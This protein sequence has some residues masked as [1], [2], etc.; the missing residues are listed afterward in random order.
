[1]SKQRP[2]FEKVVL[3][4]KRRGDPSKV[5]K[6]TVTLKSGLAVSITPLKDGTLVLSWGDKK[7]RYLNL[8]KGGYL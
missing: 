7:R 2:K 6:V 5:G 3:S 4:E 1:M 8:P